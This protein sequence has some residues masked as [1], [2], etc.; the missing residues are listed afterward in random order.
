MKN[1]SICYATF[2][3]HCFSYGCFRIGGENISYNYNFLLASL[4]GVPSK[5]DDNA[6]AGYSMGLG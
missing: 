2:E 6:D 1:D 3:K 5:L 4:N